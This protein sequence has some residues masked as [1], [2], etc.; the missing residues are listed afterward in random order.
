MTPRVAVLD[1]GCGNLASVC[2]AVR[3]VGGEPR[4]V[5]A[6]R[7]SDP[8]TRFILPGQGAF[9]AVPPILRGELEVRRNQGF[10]ILGICLGMQLMCE[11]SEEVPGVKG[12]GWIPA[13]CERLP[14]SR[15]P[16]VGWNN[17]SGGPD[18][19]FCHS[20]AI[21]GTAWPHHDGWCGLT[22]EV[23]GYSFVSMAQREN[24]WAVQFHP[25]RSGKAGLAFLAAF[26]KL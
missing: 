2:N 8:D 26:L 13:R 6:L 15:V 23:E 25:E 1:Y 11:E 20:Y 18:F 24:V 22:T 4:V 3:K 19:Y 14:L 9:C 7:A 12:L 10:P 16:H 21:P 5:L 17:V